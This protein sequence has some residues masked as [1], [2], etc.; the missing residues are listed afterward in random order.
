MVGGVRVK[1]HW[2]YKTVL[3]MLCLF[4]NDN[5]EGHILTLV[6]DSAQARFPC[7]LRMCHIPK[8]KLAFPGTYDQ[9]ANMRNME[10][11]ITFVKRLREKIDARTEVTASSRELQQYSLQ[12]TASGEIVF[13]DASQ[14]YVTR[15]R[16]T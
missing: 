6:Y 5:P 11:T 16:H 8:D 10:E 3:P 9:D 1:F 2:G 14:K 13:Y 7:K 12:V 4:V 15:L